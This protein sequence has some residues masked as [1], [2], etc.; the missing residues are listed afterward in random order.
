MVAVTSLFIIRTV[1]IH[2]GQAHAN[3]MFSF[4]EFFRLNA[5]VYNFS[6]WELP[7]FCLQGV[8]GGL[9]GA[10]FN[11]ANKLLQQF[12]MARYLNN[13]QMRWLEVMCIS[14]LMSSVSFGVPLLIPN[15]TPKPSNMEDWTDQEKD[16][17]NRLVSDVIKQ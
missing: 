16:L 14:F 10:A 6:V 17:S 5:S 4:G 11:G 12:R 8:M 3:A 2:L 13:T 15:C 1:N 7:L 9:I